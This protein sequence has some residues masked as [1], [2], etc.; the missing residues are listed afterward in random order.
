MRDQ[1]KRRGA[2][3]KL[4]LLTVA[5][6]L[7]AM[8]AVVFTGG[9]AAAHGA[10]MDPGSRTYL[11]WKYGV[12]ETGAIDP[13][14]PACA[15]ALEEGGQNAFY[16]WFAVLRSDGAGRTEGF[17]PD[18]QLCSG[19][20]TVYDFS[21]F[22][23]VHEDWPT[24]HLT[25]GADWEFTYNP[26]AHHPGTFHQYVTV[27][28]WD[29]TTPLTWDDLEDTPF[30][31]ETDPP[32]RGGVGDAES[33]YY[34]DAQLPSG[35]TGQ[36]IIYTVWERSDSEETFYGC[37]DVVFDGGN[38]EVT[39]PGGDTAASPEVMNEFTAPLD[40]EHGEHAEHGEHGAHH[41]EAAS[42]ATA[43]STGAAARTAFQQ[44]LS[45]TAG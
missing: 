7:P 30:H 43:V 1:K 5:A 27:D 11:C 35:K 28:G 2:L 18:G 34:W 9:S 23:L 15:A 14:N 20:A 41:T 25:S 24:T 22:D 29:P 26:W 6:S 10:P 4:G 31:S 39:V 12:N 45:G 37:S 33:E 17:I 8:T 3:R 44:L 16:N 13:A 32:Y 19:G 42:H 36:H 38:G 21:G 40:L